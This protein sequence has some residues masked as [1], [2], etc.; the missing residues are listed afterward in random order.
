M[1]NKFW[2]GA[3]LIFLAALLLTA[4]GTQQR[5]DAENQPE[6]P[7]TEEN[8]TADESTG[9]STEGEMEP[10]IE[11]VNDDVYRYT[12]VNQTGEPHTFEFTSSQRYDFS[13]A[14]ESGEEVFLF[15]SVSVYLQVLGEETLDQGDK[16]S[17]EFEIP[18]LELEPGTYELTAWLTPRQG[19][20]YE[21][22]TEHV[23]E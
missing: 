4:C 1:K 5:D 14:N 11:H 21:V 9:D 22:T 20:T 8:G 23:V 12:L 18:Q 6:E 7:E 19:G 13:L 10:D 3:F 16:L 15:S 2:L 17:Y